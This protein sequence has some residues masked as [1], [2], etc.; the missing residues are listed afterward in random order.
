[1]PLPIVVPEREFYDD[2]TG[3]FITTKKAVL[4]FEH[5]LLSITAWESKWHTPY[6]SKEEKT[7]E[8]SIDY[9]RCM[10][11]TK[12]A[13]PKLF[14]VIAR[15][16]VLMKQIVEYINNPMTA[17][18][19]K[20]REKQTQSREMITNELVYFWM[21]SFGIPFDPCEKWHFNRLMTL[22]EIASIKNSDPKKQKTSR[23]QMARERS[24][25]NAQRRATHHTK[26]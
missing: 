22:I 7:D 20:R 1:M 6:L 18:T 11:L 12:D 10:C 14:Y 9:L 17:T 19:I 2:R 24:A 23:S 21:T 8:Q 15:D 25:L 13:D 5:S 26:G 16:R 3:R 4:K